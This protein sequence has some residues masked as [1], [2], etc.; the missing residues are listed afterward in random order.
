MDDEIETNDDLFPSRGDRVLID[1]T[2]CIISAID[3]HE[4]D[5]DNCRW[6]T[7]CTKAWTDWRCFKDLVTTEQV[8][9]LG[10]L[11]A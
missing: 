4:R 2:V 9:C 10:C 3:Q 8:T 11:G 1:G 6:R 7:A 5:W